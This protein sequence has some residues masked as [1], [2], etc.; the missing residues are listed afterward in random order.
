MYLSNNSSVPMLWSFSLVLSTMLE[1]KQP[2]HWKRWK[3]LNTTSD[4]FVASCWRML[5]ETGQEDSKDL[6]T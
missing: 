1:P 4:L 2:R 6:N 3:F 5:P